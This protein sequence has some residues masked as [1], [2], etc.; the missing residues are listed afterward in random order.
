MRLE[1]N[2]TLLLRGNCCRRND[3]RIDDVLSTKYL[4]VMVLDI[5]VHGNVVEYI[6]TSKAKYCKDSIIDTLLN[7]CKNNAGFGT[8][9]E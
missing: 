4:R 5:Y 3:D 2:C 1:M 9:S 6:S 7:R 8:V